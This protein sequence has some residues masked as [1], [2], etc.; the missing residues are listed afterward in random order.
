[1]TR[2]K[3]EPTSSTSSLMIEH[4][5]HVAR[6]KVIRSLSRALRP[7]RAWSPMREIVHWHS[8]EAEASL[9]CA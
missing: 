9:M 7:L 2:A 8:P 4:F 3:R 1:M 6:W 5:G